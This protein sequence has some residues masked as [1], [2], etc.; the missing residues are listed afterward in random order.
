MPPD[1]NVVTKEDAK[2]KYSPLAKEIRKMYQV[3]VNIVPS[4]VGCLGVVSGRL[5]VFSK[6]FG[7][8]MCLEECRPLQSFG[9]P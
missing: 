1:G 3:L 6:I 9:P 5:D 8:Q 2:I 4:V 7:L